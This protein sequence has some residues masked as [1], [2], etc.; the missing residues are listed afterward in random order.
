M[1]Q[2]LCLIKKNACFFIASGWE[3]PCRRSGRGYMVKWANLLLLIISLLQ[4]VET[5]NGD[6]NLSILILFHMQASS[7]VHSGRF[8]VL[9][10]EALSDL[11]IK[12]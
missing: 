7:R 6:A 5:Y 4:V 1:C 9:S 11:Y 8:K 12:E 2:E 10:E 3:T